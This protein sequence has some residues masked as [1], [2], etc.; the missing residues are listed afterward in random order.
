VTLSSLSSSLGPDVTRRS[1]TIEVVGGRR[2]FGDQPRSAF[3]LFYVHL[4]TQPCIVVVA[5]RPI[6]I[7]VRDPVNTWSLMHECTV[8]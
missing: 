4:L 5:I 3:L 8:I 7:C 1:L 2:G 6:C